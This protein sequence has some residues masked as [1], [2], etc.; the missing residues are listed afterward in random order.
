LFIA[1]EIFAAVHIAIV[2]LLVWA[3]YKRQWFLKL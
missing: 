3:M 1:S 2:F